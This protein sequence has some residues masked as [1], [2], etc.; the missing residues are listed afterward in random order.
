VKK[1]P[2]VFI[3]HIVES[4]QCIE[5]Y[6]QQLTAEKFNSD[7]AMQDAIIGVNYY[8]PGLK[9]WLSL[10]IQIVVFL[11]LRKILFLL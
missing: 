2:R 4:I 6:S 3:G 7:R 5:E 11:F 8:R 1:D 9:A 10:Q